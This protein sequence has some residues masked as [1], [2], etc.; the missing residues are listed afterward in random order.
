MLEAYQVKAHQVRL[1]TKRSYVVSIEGNIRTE[2]IF[3]GFQQLDMFLDV[4]VYAAVMQ[5]SSHVA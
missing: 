2:H 4:V 3:S 1:L 5:W